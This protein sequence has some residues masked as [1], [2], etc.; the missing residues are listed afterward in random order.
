MFFFLLLY[1][2]DFDG[3]QGKVLGPSFDSSSQSSEWLAMR[4][5]VQCDDNVMTLTTSGEALAHL[6][7]DRGKTCGILLWQ[8]HWCYL[9]VVLLADKCVNDIWW[10]KMT[11]FLA[12]TMHKVH[13]YCRS[14]A[15]FERFTMLEPVLHFILSWTKWLQQNWHKTQCFVVETCS[16]LVTFFIHKPERKVTPVFIFHFR[17]SK[18]PI[19]IPKSTRNLLFY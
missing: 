18:M 2:S 7:V 16:V 9:N 8:W 6:L 10:Q 4:P 14:N 3:V 15:C 1:H 17:L 13:L 19:I 11:A 5:L 12:R